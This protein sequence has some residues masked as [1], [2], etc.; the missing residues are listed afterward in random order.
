MLQFL[1]SAT[2][3]PLASQ[4]SLQNVKNVWIPNTREI[5]SNAPYVLVGTKQDLELY[6]PNSVSLE[7]GKKFCK[8]IGGYD[9]IQ[10]RAIQCND[11]FDNGVLFF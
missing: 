7:E 4:S 11:I 9:H 2:V 6:F 1:C 3:L 8:E 5:S 10:C